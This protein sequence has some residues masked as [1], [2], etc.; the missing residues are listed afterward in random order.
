MIPTV[1]FITLP[2][3]GLVLLFY[4]VIPSERKIYDLCETM[5]VRLWVLLQ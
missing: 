1:F 4:D 5:F 2:N 3:K